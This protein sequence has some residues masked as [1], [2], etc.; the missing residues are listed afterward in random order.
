MQLNWTAEAIMNITIGGVLM[1]GTLIS[2]RSYAPAKLRA[3]LYFRL[4]WACGAFFYLFEGL[5]Y[6]FMNPFLSGISVMTTFGFAVFLTVAIGYT[7]K[8]SYTPI[9]LIVIFS[10]G[11]I[12]AYLAFQ[13]GASVPELVTGHLSLTWAGYVKVVGNAF[14]YFA[15]FYYF[16]WIVRIRKNAPFEVKQEAN[17]LLLGAIFITPVTIT[18]YNFYFLFHILIYPANIFFSLGILITIFIINREPKLLFILPFTPHQVIVKDRRSTILV[19]H[20]WSQLETGERLFS[21]IFP[22]TLH[23]PEGKRI[24]S[25]ISEI[26]FEEGILIFYES[27]LVICGL[28]LSRS[29]KFIKDLLKRFANEFEE[30]FEKI[31]KDPEKTLSDFEPAKEL[32]EK[33]FS[34]FPHRIIDNQR[35]PL[36]ISKEYYQL[37]PEIDEKLKKILKDEAEYARVKCEIQRSQDKLKALEF[38]EVYEELELEPGEEFDNEREKDEGSSREAKD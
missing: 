23:P 3:L 38:L 24:S 26:S 13:P 36:Y 7:S 8:E 27:D 30:R 18:I 21:H 1:Y 4:Y 5:S 15:A 31:L 32:I 33:Y 28:I 12:L 19:E 2:L 6:L 10:A 17:I 35:H 20:T 34:I 9:I 16:I 25:K 37:P 22:T 29:S 14:I 11:A